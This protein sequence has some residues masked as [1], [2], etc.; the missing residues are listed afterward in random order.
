MWR[1]R[2]WEGWERERRGRQCMGKGKREKRGWEAGSPRLQEAGEMGKIK[3]VWSFPIKKGQRSRSQRNFKGNRDSKVREA[4]PYYIVE[5]S[6]LSTMLSWTHLVDCHTAN[7]NSIRNPRATGLSVPDCK[8]SPSLNKVD[9]LIDWFY[10]IYLM[11]E[12]VHQFWTCCVCVCVSLY[13]SG[14]IGHFSNCYIVVVHLAVFV[15]LH[16]KRRW[17]SINIHTIAEW[18]QNNNVNIFA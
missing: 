12:L 13:W 6:P 11:P 10:F 1:V 7:G 3:I 14:N 18:H 5:T 16:R 2:D 4:G 15:L 8:V 9:W 17:R